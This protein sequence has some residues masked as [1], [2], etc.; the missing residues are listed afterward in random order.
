MVFYFLLLLFRAIADFSYIYFVNPVFAY[1]GFSLELSTL[2]YLFSWIL[3]SLSLPFVK[4]LINKVSDYIA[5]TFILFIFA[6]LTSLY[7]LTNWSLE[8]VIITFLSFIVFI[9]IARSK[10]VKTPALPEVKNGPKLALTVSIVAVVGLLSWYLVSGAGFNLNLARVYDF[11]RGN[12][13]LANIGVLAY[14]NNWTYKIFSLF[15]IA[16][17]LHKKKYLFVFFACCAQVVFYGYSAHKSVLFSIVII[18]ATWAWFSRKNN[19]YILPLGLIFVFS[20]S[21]SSYFLLNEILL[22]S[23]FIRRVF[24]VPAYLTFQYFDF[25]SNNK[26]VYWSNSILSGLIS[27]PYRMSVPMLIGDYEGSGASANNGFISSGYAHFGYMGV[28]IYTVMF[29]YLIRFFDVFTKKLGVLWLSLAITIG[30]LRS[31]LISSDLFTA[32]LTHGLLLAILLIF[33][34]RSDSTPERKFDHNK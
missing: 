33:L 25:F 29:G 14:F 4:P 5:V 3:Y 30:P 17:F 27:Y 7:G 20:A 12:A 8:P 9:F 31:A 16:Y 15:L 24:Y 19:A 32:L 22:G 34:I 13:E 1:S 6:P 18:F 23:L 2:P 11:R 26:F 28:F 21:L 10:L